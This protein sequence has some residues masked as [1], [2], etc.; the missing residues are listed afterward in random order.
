MREND[1]VPAV[2][3]GPLAVRRPVEQYERTGRRLERRERPEAAPEAGFAGREGQP[4]R[5]RWS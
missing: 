5:S 1:C 3:D 4:I 2:P